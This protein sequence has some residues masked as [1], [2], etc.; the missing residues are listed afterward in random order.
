ML[1]GL[2]LLAGCAAFSPTEPTASPTPS[3]TPTASPTL[4]PTASPTPAA[5]ATPFMSRLRE[6][7]RYVGP[8]TSS[9]AFTDWVT[10]KA[11]AGAER[12]TGRSQLGDK[13]R[14]LRSETTLAGFGL[15]FLGAHQTDW[16]FDAFDLEWDLLVQPVSGPPIWVLRFPEDFGL[17]R[18]REHL[19][20]HGFFEESLPEGVLRTHA[21][22]LEAAWTGSTELAILNTG[23]MADGRTVVLSSGEAAVR[24]MLVNGPVDGTDGPT[25]AAAE[26]L[27]EP[28]G[29]VLLIGSDTCVRLA[30]G[31]EAASDEVRDSADAVLT[32][33][34]RLAAYEALAIGYSR[35]ADPIGRIVVAYRAADRAA[36]DLAGRRLLARDG[37]SLR[38]GVP[39]AG[40]AFH[41][42]DASLADGAIV[43]KVAPRDDR[44]AAL[45]GLVPPHDMLFALCPG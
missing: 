43:L 23:L 39:Y 16:G 26:L 40:A 6:A 18:F 20:D 5:T 4:A 17:T 28:A 27:E 37:M 11:G 42:D 21:L 38:S 36:T 33:A 1:V 32:R 25:R 15:R 8:V 30:D 41:L 29:A 7:L 19:D 14:A 35:A 24:E 13:T 3:A 22:D 10:T 44:P 9:I 34:G 12:L 31:L 45:L 2:L